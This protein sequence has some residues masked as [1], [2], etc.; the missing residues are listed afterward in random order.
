MFCHQISLTTAKKHEPKTWVYTWLKQGFRVCQ[1]GWVNPKPGFY[2]GF[3]KSGFQSLITITILLPVFNLYQFLTN[4]STRQRGVL[5][6]GKIFNVLIMSSIKA[7]HICTITSESQ[8]HAQFPDPKSWVLECRK[9]RFT[10]LTNVKVPGFSG[11]QKMQVQVSNCQ[12][13]ECVNARCHCL[14]VVQTELCTA[15]KLTDIYHAA[16]PES[17]RQ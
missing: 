11:F 8:I 7:Y 1:N 6:M 16:V 12:Q 13:K 15:L 10:M 5:C 2:P 17:C 3:P 4:R 14:R 9:P